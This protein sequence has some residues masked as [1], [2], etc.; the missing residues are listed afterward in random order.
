MAT[1]TARNL[2]TLANSLRTKARSP[3]ASAVAPLIGYAVF[4]LTWLGR[5][6]VLHPQ[7]RVF[8]DRF[9]DKTIF[10]WSFLWWPHQVAHGHDP[11]VTKAIWVPHGIDLAWVTSMPGASLLLWPLSETLGPV[12]A[13][14]VAALAAPTLAAWTT[15]LLARRLSSS[16]PAALVAGF[17]FGFSPYIAGQSSS[18]LNLTLVFLVPLLGFLAVVF[19]Q[20]DLGKR[21]YVALSALAL[22][23]QFYFS[24]EIFA[25]FTLVAMLCFA[26]G[27]LLLSPLR[28]VLR[29]LGGYTL[30]AYALAACL[31]MKETAPRFRPGNQFSFT[32]AK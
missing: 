11:F 9:A 12:F 6:V 8:G 19:A 3:V 24:T 13:Y 25:T 22:A 28:P 32:S 29:A 27:W 14:N 21:S 31:A 5:G 16:T 4:A 23:L 30:L 1:A 17:L 18:H 20:G 15:F 10:M 7:S 26:I 2:P